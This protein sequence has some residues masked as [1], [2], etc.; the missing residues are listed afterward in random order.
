MRGANEA[1]T[2]FRLGRHIDAYMLRA[3]DGD[4]LNACNH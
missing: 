4:Y 3:C 1:I 2:K